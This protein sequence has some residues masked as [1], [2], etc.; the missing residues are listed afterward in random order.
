LPPHARAMDA[1]HPRIPLHLCNR[2]ADGL[3]VSMGLACP[4]ARMR[5]SSKR[6]RT[7]P[8]RRSRNHRT[9]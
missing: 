7:C 2:D 6:V 9:S 1:A 4:I 8:P 3:G 5:A